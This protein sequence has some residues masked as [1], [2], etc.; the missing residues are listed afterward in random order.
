MTIGG[1][2]V[3]EQNGSV[4]ITSRFV[5]AKRVWQVERIV[6]DPVYKVFRLSTVYVL[7]NVNAV[8]HWKQIIEKV[9]YPVYVIQHHRDDC[10]QG[11]WL[12]TNA[13]N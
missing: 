3:V 5:F 1:Y 7:C 2:K 9:D 10:H 11:L 13:W 6:N 8:N 12:E 4:S